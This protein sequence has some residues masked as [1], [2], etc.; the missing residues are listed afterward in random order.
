[1]QVITTPKEAA[2]AGPQWVERVDGRAHLVVDLAVPLTALLVVIS[3][4]GLD[5]SNR[6]RWLY[7]VVT[8]FVAATAPLGARGTWYR[9]CSITEI[10][11][12]WAWAALA[13]LFVFQ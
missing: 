13:G 11:A 10:A 9:W 3:F 2:T 5:T 6:Q 4:G 1:M 12:W 7:F 8:T